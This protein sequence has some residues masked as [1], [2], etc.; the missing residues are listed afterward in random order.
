MKD[1]LKAYLFYQ[2]KTER[3]TLF[4][5]SPE[6]KC[7]PGD[8]RELRFGQLFHLAHEVRKEPER[9][10]YRRRRAHIDPGAA[11]QGD[12]VGRAAAGE[13]AQVI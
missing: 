11:Q 9:V 7:K 3:S 13:E 4:E 6:E 8:F 5:I 1:T 10:F 2:K 12:R